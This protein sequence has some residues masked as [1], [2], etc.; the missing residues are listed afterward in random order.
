MREIKFRAG[1]GHDKRMVYWTL[2]DLLCRFGEDEYKD[3]RK[4]C[5]PLFD[6]KQYTEQKDKD[7]EE[8]YDDFIMEKP[9]GYKY[10]VEQKWYQVGDYKV[11]G[12]EDM[13]NDKIIGNKFE[14]PEL[15]K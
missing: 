8:I 2:N 5:S 11:F 7:K 1:D 15:L 10:L 9:T 3:D 13:S 12:Y 14:N 4:D 6:W